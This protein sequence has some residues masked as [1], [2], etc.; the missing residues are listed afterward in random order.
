ELEAVYENGRAVQLRSSSESFHLSKGSKSL[1]RAL[2]RLKSTVY[3]YDRESGRGVDYRDDVKG[4]IAFVFRVP[5]IKGSETD[6]PLAI[7]VHRRGQPA[8]PT[9][10]KDPSHTGSADRRKRHK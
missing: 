7:I 9:D 3:L 2:P 5:P 8:I 6:Q 1:Q 10:V 4:G